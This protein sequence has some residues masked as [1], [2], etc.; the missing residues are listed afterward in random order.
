[1]I[2]THCGSRKEYKSLS[3]KYSMVLVMQ[4]VINSP[5]DIIITELALKKTLSIIMMIA[6]II[7]CLR[8]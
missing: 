3:V 1:M 7:S 6:Q 8:S 4:H 5:S 2:V